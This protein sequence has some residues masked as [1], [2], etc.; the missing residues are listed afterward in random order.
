[1][2]A[3]SQD[4]AEGR[5]VDG[6]VGGKYR[7]TAQIGQG[8]M[9]LVYRAVDEHLH[10]PVAIK[11]LPESSLGDSD[12][13]ARFQ[14]ESRALAALNHPHIL[15]IYEVGQANAAPFIAMELVEGE[16]LRDHL[17][18]GPLR[19]A[20]AMDV[21]LQI[22][23]GL[24]AAHRKGIVH[25]D[26]KPENVMIRADGYVKVLDFGLAALCAPTSADGSVVPN[27]AFE[28]VGAVV[29]GTPAYMSPEQIQ[30]R[31]I[32][33]RSDVFSL[34]VT[35]CEMIAGTNP[36]ARTTVIETIGAIARTPAPIE[37]V[38][39][40]LPRDVRDVLRR[41]LQAEAS[42]RYQ[43]AD[44]LVAA[45]ERVRNETD[46]KRPSPLLSHRLA[47]VAIGA[48]LLTLSALAGTLYWRMHR[49]QWVRGSAIPAIVRLA[50]EQKSA[51]AFD[52]IQTAEK[53]APSDPDLAR[54][55][56]A[57]TRVASI[58]SSPPG[59]LVEVKD[60]LFPG[61]PWIRIGTTPLDNVRIPSG[62][63]RYRVS[64]EAVG[65]SITAPFPSPSLQFDL[66]GAVH[67]PSRMVPVGQGTWLS[68]LGFLGWLGPYDLPPFLMDRYEVTNREYQ[69][70]V[71]GGGYMRREFWKEPFLRDGRAVGWSDAMSVMR[72]RTGRAG[73]STWEGG[74]YPDGEGDYPVTGVSWYEAAAYAEFKGKS[75]P[76]IAQWGEAAPDHL[77]GYVAQV[78]NLSQRLRETSASTALGPYGTYDLVGN[79]REWYWNATA[80]DRRL[81]LGRQPSSYGPEALQPFDRS[82]L[83]GFRCVRN[84]GPLP[85]AA[86]AAVSFL[87]RDFRAATPASDQ[88]FSAYR[89]MYAYDKTPLHA[90]VETKVVA[91]TDWT[92]SRVTFDAAYG[93]ER[94]SALLFLPRRARPPYQVVVFFPSARVNFLH[95]SNDPGDL[96]FVDYVIKS[97][98]AVMYPIYQYLY[99]RQTNEPPMPGPT[100]RRETVI[101]WSKDLGRSIDYLETRPDIDPARIGYL[102]VSQGA[103][104]GVIL[105]ALE[106]RLK[107][108][109][110][111]DGGMFQMAHPIPGLDQVDFAARITAPVLMVNGR[112]DATFPLE[113]AQEP[114]F[115]MLATP[116]SDKRHVVFDT[117]HDVRLRSADL[118]RE[119]LAWFDKYLGR[120]N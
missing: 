96:T 48:V 89:A 120:V 109:V 108:I 114:L 29:A 33:G 47:A 112:Y 64:K 116:E 44:D 26:V 6:L 63:L 118:T 56:A 42:E 30:G 17:K 5:A 2:V 58:H 40:G 19:F 104:S 4:C 43:T 38:T 113:A 85:K 20:E 72:D 31:P 79:A 107:A 103:A 65:E 14:N 95:D 59:A 32:D 23:R 7:I 102:G 25:R 105:T 76:V 27:A 66:A 117:P 50:S 87:R 1:V 111:L 82:A 45:L 78:S 57:A 37:P 110:F 12:R 115:R 35:L 90:G 8:G 98:R 22:A 46:A 21:G 73:P 67:A 13:L 86:M 41:T 77:D 24:A 54:A 94:M 80:D 34:G 61:E 62:Y 51:S 84:D 88:V 9:G 100:L 75:L 55:I 99:E 18:S 119:V 60:Y 106:P 16:T 101:E 39:A 68:Y 70:F 15:T 36:F 97:G 81:L 28:T 91:S 10:R 74:H 69:E 11:F 52:M 53:Y 92:R 49:L 3:G 71:D 93:N 83:N